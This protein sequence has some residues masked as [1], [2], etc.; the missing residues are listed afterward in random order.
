MVDVRDIETYHRL[1]QK[2]NNNQL[3]KETIVRFVN[4]QFAE[5]LSSKQNIS[6]T[7][8]SNKLGFPRSTQIYFM[9]NI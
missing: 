2:E 4:R 6:S 1:L 7:I 8:D 9:G 5:D 3:P